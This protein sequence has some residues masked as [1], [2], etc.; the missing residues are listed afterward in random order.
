[1]ASS[2][3]EGGARSAVASGECDCERFGVRCGPYTLPSATS[4]IC[5]DMSGNSLEL[6][7]NDAV[8]AGAPDD[9]AAIMLA[10]GAL[11]D[12]SD[13]DAIVPRELARARI[14]ADS[15]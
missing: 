2:A 6:A 14:E 15:L 4:T 1:M 11:D 3:N 10:A 9:S 5:E 8:S 13:V 12:A 7:P